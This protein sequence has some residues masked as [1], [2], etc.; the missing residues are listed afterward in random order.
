MKKSEVADRLSTIEDAFFWRE[1]E[2]CEC[3]G[4]VLQALRE[5]E[6]ALEGLFYV[7]PRAQ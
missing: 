2:E 4:E 1:S 5:C 3:E 7:L 6:R